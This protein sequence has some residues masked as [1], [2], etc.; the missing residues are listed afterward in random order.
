MNYYILH[1]NR[2]QALMLT[3][4]SSLVIT[5]IASADGPQKTYNLGSWHVCETTNFRVFAN[6]N[7][8]RAKAIANTCERART[9]IVT[10]WTD[11]ASSKTWQPKCDVYVHTSLSCYSRTLGPSVG[12]SVG[13]ATTR[14]DSGR[15]VQRRIDLRQD[16]GGWE[17]DALPHELTHI[18][19]ADLFTE[20]ELPRWMDEGMGILLES[21]RKRAKRLLALTGTSP[22]L[23]FTAEQ[24]FVRRDY[25]CSSRIHAF[26]AQSASLVNFLVSLRGGANF[27]KFAKLSIQS[28]YDTA[29]RKIYG[30]DKVADLEKEWSR[31]SKN[32]PTAWVAD[33]RLQI[34]PL[35]LES[36]S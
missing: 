19:L 17:R 13:C 5:Q 6:G 34:Q 24:F 4:I 28:G 12:R 7:C 33:V 32:H 27:V 36:N 22:Q 1:H 25:P 21:P 8:G 31:H 14:V 20:V 11:G 15:V 9:T 30:I 35:E 23:H 2:V 29:L 16:A 3:I 26:Y 18:V 10:C